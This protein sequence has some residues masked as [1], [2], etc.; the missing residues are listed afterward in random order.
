MAASATL[1]FGGLCFTGVW[2]QLSWPSLFAG[3][4]CALAVRPSATLMSRW[5][6]QRQLH[7]PLHPLSSEPTVSNSVFI[8]VGNVGI[9]RSHVRHTQKIQSERV[10]TTQVHLYWSLVQ[11]QEVTPQ[12]NGGAK[13]LLLQTGR[14]GGIRDIWNNE[15]RENV[16]WRCV[17]IIGGTVLT[18]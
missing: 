4:V 5:H 13:P 16:R 8:L 15:M 6:S 7:S 3:N 12:Q 9:S 18:F 11:R 1:R 2:Q 17:D 10:R 14:S